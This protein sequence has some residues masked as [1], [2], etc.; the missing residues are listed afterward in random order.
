MV[1]LVVVLD[2]DLPVGVELSGA[3]VGERSFGG[4]GGDGQQFVLDA[5]QGLGEARR[6]VVEVDPKE[7]GHLLEAYRRHAQVADL[8]APGKEQATVEVVCPG[9]V[10]AG[11]ARCR[12]DV[13]DEQFV[14]P[15][16]ADVVHGVQ[17]AVSLSDDGDALVA[18]RGGQEVTG[19]AQLADVADQLP[20]ACEDAV[21]FLGED[22]RFGVP[23]AA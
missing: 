6:I 12:A 3:A 13:A 20:R 16:L 17:R 7:A 8:F 23:V 11:D 1:A 10:R 5:R 19:R 9:V 18:D 2:G 22:R 21:E 4:A 15:M 14:A